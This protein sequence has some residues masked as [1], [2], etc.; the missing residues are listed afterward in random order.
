MLWIRR[1]KNLKKKEIA[2]KFFDKISSIFIYMYSFVN[3]FDF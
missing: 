3:F 1:K 2:V